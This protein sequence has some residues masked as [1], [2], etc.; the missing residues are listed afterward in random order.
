MRTII[1]SGSVL[2]SSQPHAVRRM[3]GGWAKNPSLA[4]AYGGRQSILVQRN[5]NAVSRSAV[6]R[7][8]MGLPLV[9]SRE[10]PR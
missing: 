2:G 7:S 10:T 1:P 5:I 6:I 4:P 3:R 8:M 9:F